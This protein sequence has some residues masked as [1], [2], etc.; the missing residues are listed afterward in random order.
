MRTFVCE[1]PIRTQSEANKREHWSKRHKRLS[2]HR[3]V[4]KIAMRNIETEYMSAP[5]YVVKMTRIGKKLL[6]DDNLAGSFKGVRDGVA[7]AF[8]LDDGDERFR[9]IYAQEIGR[10]YKIVVAIC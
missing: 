3:A 5:P 10:E 8:R 2:A 4:T 9:W 7:E 1:L 6:D